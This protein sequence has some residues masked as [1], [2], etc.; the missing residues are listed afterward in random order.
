MH[1]VLKKQHTRE[2]SYDAGNKAGIKRHIAVDTQSWSHAIMVTTADVGD[3]AGAL[4]ILQENKAFI[5]GLEFAE[6]YRQIAP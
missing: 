5:K 3:H 6:S 2:K 4:A 1:K